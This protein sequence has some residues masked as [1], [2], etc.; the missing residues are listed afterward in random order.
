MLLNRSYT[1][2]IPDSINTNKLYLIAVLKTNRIH[3]NFTTGHVVNIS[4]SLLIKEIIRN[5]YIRRSK[6][7]YLDIGAMYF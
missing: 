4:D 7:V 6:T 2:I 1:V 5:N 3:E